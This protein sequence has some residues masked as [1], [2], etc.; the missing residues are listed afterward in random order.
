MKL[1]VT[2]LILILVPLCSAYAQVDT[3]AIQDSSKPVPAHPAEII[4][5]QVNRIQKTITESLEKISPPL[6][7]VTALD[8]ISP[9]DSLH[10]KLQ[11]IV[12]NINK[13]AGDLHVALFNSYLS[14]L[15]SH[16]VFRGDI[17]PVT[18]GSMSVEFDSIPKGIYSVAV[19][20][21]ENRDGVLGKNQ[22]N[23]PT[24]GYGFSNNIGIS[25]G[26]PNFN[27]TKFYYSGKNKTISINMIYF[28][29]SK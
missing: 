13:I 14:F 7:L 23:I 3:S 26:P 21:D 5:P 18:S 24:E 25:I 2:I 19:F 10:G 8:S 9:F 1:L 17:V 4:A 27:Q 20:H 22:F 16:P 29:G 12:K 11:V 28:R 6:P 15:N